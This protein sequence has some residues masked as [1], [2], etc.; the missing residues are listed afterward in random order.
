MIIWLINPYG[1]I[2]GESWRD[3]SFSMMAEAFAVRGHDVVWWTSN[4]SHHFKRFRSKSCHDM[5]INEHFVV[6]LVPT[7][8]YRKNI[9]FG[10]ILRDA[11]FAYR[12]Y[13]RGKKMPAPDCII[14]SESPL[15]LGFA[16]QK[17]AQYHNCPVVFHQMDLWPELFEQAFPRFIRPIVKELLFPIYRNRKKT[18]NKLS[19]VTALAK[20]YLMVPLNEAPAL[21]SRPHAIIYNGIDV[22]HFRKLMKNDIGLNGIL[23]KK[24]E[25]E[26]WAVFAGSLGPS[27]DILTLIEVAKKL[28]NSPLKLR[29][30]VAGDGPHRADLEN[31]MTNK[32]SRL[33]Y[34]GKLEPNKLASLYR[35]CDIGLCTYS[36]RSNVEMPDKIY[37]YTAAGLPVINS[38]RGEVSDIVR[39]KQIGLQYR[40]GDAND[41]FLVLERLASDH[42]LRQEMAKN[43]FSI[44]MEYDKNIQYKKLVELAEKLCSRC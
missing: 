13:T 27:Y 20:P 3:Y 36:Q 40:A 6:R 32:N 26:I 17:L 10:R 33:H 22:Q 16:G 43:S 4:F 14:Y 8:G 7:T 5:H 23:P 28:E 39:E 30:I 35:I 12:S 41:L 34:A 11:V 19:A 25:G 38:L 42:K 15:T 18:Y 37:D 24:E 31:H 1:P 9:G 21:R 29:I 2:P 44:G